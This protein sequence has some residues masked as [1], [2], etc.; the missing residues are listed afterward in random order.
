MR[1]MKLSMFDASCLLDK[2]NLAK[3]L[4]Y[5]NINWQTM[6]IAKACKM[7]LSKK[8]FVFIRNLMTDQLVVLSESISFQS[9]CIDWKFIVLTE[10]NNM[11]RHL[12][13]WK[14]F[15]IDH[16]F[17]QVE[18]SSDIWLIWFP[19]HYY[20]W[21]TNSY[22]CLFW[23]EFEMY[24]NFKR[25]I[26][27]DNSRYLKD[28]WWNILLAIMSFI[29]SQICNQFCYYHIVPVLASRFWILIDHDSSI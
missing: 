8:V 24:S 1:F 10:Q 23:L 3:L 20:D 27:H 29:I 5:V 26:R 25:E 28:W 6:S 15:V 11:M 7:I 18:K 19:N 12:N 4:A 2:R 17:V 22:H 9:I 16:L 21:G 14:P 13:E